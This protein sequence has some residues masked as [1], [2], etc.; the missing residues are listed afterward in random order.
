V[1]IGKNAELLD[2]AGDGTVH[3][4][5]TC[6]LKS[7][8]K[9]RGYFKGRRYLLSMGQMLNEFRTSGC[10]NVETGIL[11]PLTLLL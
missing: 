4:V 3:V 11:I 9:Y 7:L 8:L 6:V 2:I 5:T 1:A 10:Y